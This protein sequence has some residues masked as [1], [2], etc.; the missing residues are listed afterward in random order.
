MLFRRLL[1]FFNLQWCQVWNGRFFDKLSLR[2]LGLRYQLGHGGAKCPYPSPGPSDLMVFDTSGVHYVAVNYC[3]CGQGGQ[4]IHQRTQ[5]LRSRWFPATFDRPKT[6][7]TFDCLATF[8]ELTLQGKTTPFDFYHT[9]LRRTDNAQLSKTIVSL[10]H[11]FRLSCTDA[12]S[13]SLPGISI[14]YADLAAFK[15]AYSGRTWP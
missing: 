11:S 14:C 1:P 15:D 9:I 5:L 4:V 12:I 2:E 3:D 10:F 7:F 8:H 6:V 13:V